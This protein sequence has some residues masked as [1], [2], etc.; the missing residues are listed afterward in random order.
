MKKPNSNKRRSK[1]S[2]LLLSALSLLLSTSMLVGSTFAWF[3]DSV[4]STGNIVQSG[5]LDVQMLWADGDLDP[6]ADETTWEDA[7]KGAIFNY[8][9]WEPGYVQARH[10]KITNTGD[11]ALKYQMRIIANGV[12]S[13]L[14]DV[15]DV[16]FFDDATQVSRTNIPEDKKIG[17][18]SEVLLQPSGSIISTKIAGKLTTEAGNSSDTVTLVLKMREDAD[19]KYQ[20]LSIGSDFSVQLLATQETYEKDSFDEL[21]DNNADYDSQEV[22]RAMVSKLTGNELN[23][24]LSATDSVTLNAGYQFEPTETKEQGYASKWANAHADFYVY[25]DHDVAANSLMLAGYYKLFCDGF[26]GG[27]WVGLS[28]DTTIP[29]SQG[30]RLIADGMNGGDTD[31]G[32]TI[33]YSAICEYGNDGTGFR[34][35]IADLDGSN[36]GTTVTVEL[37]LYETYTREEAMDKFG[38]NTVNKETGDYITVGKF[39]YTFP[40]EAAPSE[41][42]YDANSMGGLYE[43][44][45][46]LQAGD[47]L[48]LPEG[49]YNTSGTF[50]IPAGVTIKGAEGTNV[51]FHQN[52]AVQDNIFNCE[53]DVTIENITFESNRKGYAICDNSKD[54]D[55]D[56]NITV[57]NC[58]FK[59]VATDKNYGIYKNLNGSLTV[60]NCTFDNYNNAICG[61]NNGNGSTTEI[62]GCTF[63]NINGE[64]IGYVKAGVPNN[65]ETEVIANNTGLTEDNVIGYP[66]SD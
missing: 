27:Y 53:G 38:E 10:L 15:I 62:T 46:T 56:G 54:H 59:G 61:V 29:A 11:L 21:Y 49:T 55:T 36:Q 6:N 2:A 40:G 47:V 13:E 44:L 45:P 58:K 37:R 30:V 63:T 43:Y 7:S 52:S 18:L 32:I 25:A 34:C 64:A 33:P 28:A 12:V 26:N 20:N 41:I 14:A 51:V 60:K 8:T 31:S 50:T 65:F 16:Y 3:T 17:T 19:N 22:P 39:T 57:I 23:I 35:G 42:V 1:K 4:T 66:I 48:V 5:T 9:K 24:N